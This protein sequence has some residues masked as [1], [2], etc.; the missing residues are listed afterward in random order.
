MPFTDREQSDLAYCLLCC[1][2]CTFL[3]A[4]PLSSDR[5]RFGNFNSNEDYFQRSMLG[6]PL[7]SCWSF[8][9]CMGQCIP[10]TCGI[11]QYALRRKALN[12]NMKKYTCCQGYYDGFCCGLIQSNQLG[13]QNCPDLCAFVEGCFCNSCAVSATRLYVIEKYNLRTDPCDNRIIFLN[14]AIQMLACIFDILAIWIDDLRHARLILDHIA[15]IVYHITSGMMTAQVSI[16][17]DYQF[18]K[19]GWDPEGGKRLAKREA[20]QVLDSIGYEDDIVVVAKAE[21]YHV[22]EARVDNEE[23]NA[24]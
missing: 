23:D 3:P 12:Y 14:N 9:W 1:I 17:L 2:P 18:N 22:K 10:Y 7:Y 4:A 24:V 13:E 5:N 19:S 11:T 15:D 6:A 21:P 8:I 20:G 16:E